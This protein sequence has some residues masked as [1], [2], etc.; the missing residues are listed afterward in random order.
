MTAHV[1][2][3]FYQVGYSETSK[4]C[5]AFDV[6][7]SSEE[8]YKL[9]PTSQQKHQDSITK[10]NWL[11]C[12]ENKSLFILRRR[13]V[14]EGEQCTERFYVLFD[15]G[16]R[17]VIRKI[18]CSEASQA[19]PTR[20]SSKGKPELKRNCAKWTVWIMQQRKK[21]SIWSR[22][23]CLEGH[24]DD[25]IGFVGLHAGK[26]SEANFC[27]KPHETRKHFLKL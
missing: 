2:T 5:V 23:V 14:R 12:S 10:S 15:H 8:Y 26:I 11:C 20:P 4:F 3:E 21:L 17:G 16:G 25:E 19:V 1:A 24:H 18:H 22:S 6:C 13:A 7:N 9:R 27:E